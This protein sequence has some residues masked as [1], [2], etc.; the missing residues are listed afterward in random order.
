MKNKGFTLVELMIVVAIVSILASI[1]VPAYN[2]YVLR[3][4]LTEAMTEL[5]GMRVKLEQYYQDYRNYGSASCGV[6]APTAPAVKHFS[7]TC[8][9]GATD[10][11]YTA[12]ATG[13]A[14][15]G[16]GNFIYTI[17]Q[18]NNKTTEISGG[19]PINCWARKEDGSC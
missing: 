8:D 18:N 12:T 13:I 10:Q 11:S 19:T 7:Y 9:L 6:A 2:N 14:A 17:D 16:T 1:A 4:K 5:A 3:G 15:Q